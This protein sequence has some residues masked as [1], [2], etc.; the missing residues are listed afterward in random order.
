M[1]AP[2]VRQRLW[3]RAE[4]LVQGRRPGD[5]NSAMMELG[6]TVCMPRGPKCLICPVAKYCKA[7]AAGV[8]E[9]LPAP[10]RRVQTPLLKRDVICIRRGGKWLIEQRPAKGR[11]ASMWQFVTIEANGSA[12]TAAA[13]LKSVGMTIRGLNCLGIV[14]HSL[15][16]RRYEYGIYMGEG[17]GRVGSRARGTRRWVG[18]GEL[19]QF[20]LPRPHVKVAEMLG[21]LQFG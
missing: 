21:E 16:H 6:A 20:P 4:Q 18:L 10:K 14:T 7:Q 2:K 17:S 11:W 15:T 5:F 13:I 1:S 8:Q 3:S 12:P 19:G 9:S